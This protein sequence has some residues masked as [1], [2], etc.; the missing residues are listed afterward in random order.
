VQKVPSVKL[1]DLLK[2]QSFDLIFMDIEGSEYF[3]MKGMPNL[4]AQCK[5]LVA[6]F[7]PHHLDRVGGISVSDFIEPLQ[8]FQS[9]LI[10]SKNLLVQSAN[11]LDELTHM[12]HNGEG[13]EGLIF[14]KNKIMKSEQD[15]TYVA[16]NSSTP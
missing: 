8:D 13:D 16:D 15:G 7:I 3:A 12:C 5:V 10:P 4:L 1:D 9:L 14:F 2:D 11:F 6:E